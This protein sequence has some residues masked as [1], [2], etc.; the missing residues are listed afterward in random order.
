MWVLLM[1]PVAA[2][3]AVVAMAGPRRLA[4]E[5]SMQEAAGDLAALAVAFRDYEG[6][7]QGPLPVLPPWCADS[8]DIHTSALEILKDRARTSLQRAGR[9]LSPPAPNHYINMTVA[10]VQALSVSQSIKDSRADLEEARDGLADLRSQEAMFQ[11]WREPCELL[12]G[13]LVEDLTSLGFE[14]ES[15]RGYYTDALSTAPAAVPRPPCAL[16][17]TEAALDAVHVAVAADWERPGW[18]PYQVWRGRTTLGAESMGVVRG[19]SLTPTPDCGDVLDVRDSRGNPVWMS[20]PDP[21]NAPSREL[22]Q[23]S[24]R[25]SLFY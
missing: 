22:M 6:S 2:F 13:I 20:I 18:G 21:N 3:A 11:R 14:V 25:N 10:D 24:R 7:G 5:S 17:P 16:S 9:A 4:A 15:L 8:H 23:S 1:V 19:L 12:A